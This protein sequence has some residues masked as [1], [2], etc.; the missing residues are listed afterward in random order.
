[1]PGEEER[2][3][4]GD[5]RQNLRPAVRRLLRWRRRGRI[6]SMMCARSPSASS[7][8]EWLSPGNAGW[9]NLWLKSGGNTL[10]TAGTRRN[11][12]GQK[13][14]AWSRPWQSRRLPLPRCCKRRCLRVTRPRSC[15]ASGV[16]QRLR[17]LCHLLRLAPFP[18]AKSVVIRRGTSQL[19]W[20]YLLRT[21]ECESDEF[22]THR[23]HFGYI[24]VF[25]K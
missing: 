22:G 9:E 15:P 2:L 8:L 1:M 14:G 6:S 23:V 7:C 3:D 24:L 5:P 19:I 21:P 16:R 25:R 12:R 10:T 11:R 17:R 20:D 13:R 18:G 4:A